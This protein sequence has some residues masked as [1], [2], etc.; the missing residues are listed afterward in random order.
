VNL[1]DSPTVLATVAHPEVRNRYGSYYA[2]PDASISDA[3]LTDSEPK[4]YDLYIDLDAESPEGEEE[5]KIAVL[6]M[7]LQEEGLD[8]VSADKSSFG[9][10]KMEIGES[11]DRNPELRVLFVI[12]PE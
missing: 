10:R 5:A 8:A 4:K 1:L 7:R 12:I 6:P 9:R 2:V 3:Y 11:D